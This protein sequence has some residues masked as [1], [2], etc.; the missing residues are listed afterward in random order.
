MPAL[1]TDEFIT[2]VRVAARLPGFDEDFTPARILREGTWALQNVFPKAVAGT[3]QGYALVDQVVTISAGQTS[4]RI[5]PRAMGNSLVRVEVAQLADAANGSPVNTRWR[6][7][8]NMTRQQ[9]TDK[10]GRIQ[11]TETTHFELRMAHL[12]LYPPP[13]ENLAMRFQYYLRPPDL[14]TQADATTALGSTDL[15][16]TSVDSVNGGDTIYTYTSATFNG[17][18]PN[19]FCDLQL[20]IGSCATI[21]NVTLD[22]LDATHV[23]AMHEGGSDITS[24]F[25]YMLQSSYLRAMP[26]G[27][28]YILPLPEEFHQPLAYWAAA[29]ILAERGDENKAKVLVDRAQVSTKAMVDLVT[30]RVKSQLPTL[31]NRSSWLR[32]RGSRRWH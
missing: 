23:R 30:P 10:S 16:L 8:S 28:T 14:I 24:A 32:R 9:T 27:Q 12:N 4:V 17:S 2:E 31:V 1:T 26:A 6:A 21:P 15:R 25:F 3:H 18:S 5:P 20:P 11:Q 7:L 29:Q 13:G 19:L 22:F